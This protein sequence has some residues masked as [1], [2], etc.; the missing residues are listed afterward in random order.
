[1][2]MSKQ[3]KILV[4]GTSRK[5]RGGITSVIK[6]HEQGEQWKRFK[7]KWIET[8][9]DTNPIDKIYYFTT[10]LLQYIFLLPFYDIV[11]IHLAVV[12]RKLVFFYLAKFF[13][14]KTIVHLHVPDPET[15]ING[16]N[17]HLYRKIMQNADQ[18]IVLS[19]FWRTQLKD[20]LQITERV[21]TIY[22]PCPTIETVKNIDKKNQ[23][24]FAGTIS[25]RKGYDLLLRAFAPISQKHPNWNIALAGN[26]EITEAEQL[27]KELHIEKQVTLLG[28]ISG[29]KKA[30]AFS[31]SKIFCLPSYSEGFPM[32]VLDAWAFG[33]PV[34]CT[35]V[36]GLTD[37]VVDEKNALV[38]ECGDIET[39]TKK[40][41]TLI[42]NE[43][44]YNRIAEQ[45]RKLSQ[46]SFNLVTINQQ[47]ADLYL[48]IF[49]NGH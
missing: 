32:A 6:A 49:N 7:C 34:I 9:I 5:T 27:A 10:A 25:K 40:L 33:L 31:S 13:K 1:M 46:T 45:S 24:L 8:H 3:A 29:D 37:I 18:V 20:V 44:L 12:K 17:K 47:I 30:E 38:F 21:T 36:G 43:T 39:L 28:W 41:D 42:S 22:N 26:G 48:K 14:K 35:P 23:I 11:H 4:I 2:Y 15:S 19:E 16:K